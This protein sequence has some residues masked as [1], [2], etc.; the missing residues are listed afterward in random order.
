MHYFV[1]GTAWQEGVFPLLLGAVIV[2]KIFIW[3]SMVF[4]YWEAGR[5]GSCCS[6]PI[7]ALQQE[8]RNGRHK[9][10]CGL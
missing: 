9:V 5:F 4:Q 7:W 10:V 3:L 6:L 8:N 2:I 1:L